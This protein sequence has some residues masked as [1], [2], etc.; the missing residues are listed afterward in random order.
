MLPKGK[1]TIKYRCWSKQLVQWSS[2]EQPLPTQDHFGYPPAKETWLP[3]REKYW[4]H[5][6]F[7][8]TLRWRERELHH[9]QNIDSYEDWGFSSQPL[10]DLAE[11]LKSSLPLRQ[12]WR[13]LCA[14]DPDAN[15]SCSFNRVYEYVACLENNIIP[16]VEGSVGNV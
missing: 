11:T 6:L 14:R 10:A 8:A 1:S 3:N 13:E 5:T 16:L 7:K 12:E 15:L 9:L 2:H 4:I